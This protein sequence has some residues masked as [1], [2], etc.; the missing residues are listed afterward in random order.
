MDNSAYEIDRMAAQASL[1]EEMTSLGVEAHR[2][3]TENATLNGRESGT[4]AGNFMLQHCIE[5]MTEAIVAFIAKAS[6]GRAGRRHACLQYMQ[7]VDPQVLALI[8]ARV[9]LDNITLGAL[10]SA[11]AVKVGSSVEDEA[12]FSKFEGE[13]KK[14]FRATLSGLKKRTSN[15]GWKRKVLLH[16]MN[17]KTDV[18]WSSWPKAGRL[19]LGNAL[20]E[21]FI[22]NTGLATSVT[23]TVARKRQRTYIEATPATMD[24]IKTRNTACEVLSPSWLPTIV[25]P[26]PWTTPTD[27]G[28]WFTQ[29]LTLV[30][31]GNQN[32]LEELRGCTEQM[33]EVYSAV[34][35]MQATGWKVNKQVLE[36]VN[37]C[38]D[39]SLGIAK[40]P[41][42]EPVD[43]PTRPHDIDTNKESLTMWKRAAARVH[44]A[45]SKASSQRLQV[46]KIL[47]I[48]KRFESEP[49]IFFPTQLDF[50]GRSYCIPQQLN[51]Q[52]PDVAKSLLTFSEGK[53]LGTHNAVEWLAVHGANCF[54]EDKSSLAERIA[55]VHAHSDE[56]EQVGYAPMDNL[57]WAGADKPFQFLAFCYEWA[58]YKRHGLSFVSH[59]PIA[60]DGTCNGLQ[61]FSALLR[62]RVGGAA[63]NLV[64]SPTPNDIYQTVA[65]VVIS[66][67]DSICTISALTAGGTKEGGMAK[68][69]NGLTIDRKL[70]KRPVMVLPY[71]GTIFSTRAYVYEWMN[72][73]PTL[74]WVESSEMF[75]ASRF[76]ADLV[77]EAIGEVVVSA[78]EAMKWLQS[79]AR[80]TTKAGIPVS[81]TTPDGLPILQSYWETDTQLVKTRMGD[82][83]RNIS[84]RRELPS[85]DSKR[86]QNG[87]SPNFIHALDA[88]AMRQYVLLAET[89]GISSF[90]LIH[91][92]YG[93]HAA[94][95]EVSAACIRAAFVDMYTETN[96]LEDFRDQIASAL[97]LGDEVIAETPERGDLVLEE[98]LDSEYFFA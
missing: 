56:I 97:A 85:L 24:L 78:K 94:D 13:S 45:N 18:E 74:P 77:W 62:D 28:Y 23:R 1:E 88:T 29:R 51:P 43:L 6:T 89:N 5:P 83:V 63:T 72:E 93:T 59:L 47:W 49:E 41:Q 69:W 95:A 82:R 76:M 20:L 2:L 42:Q 8:T 50:R 71:G 22:Q 31:T 65:D 68:Q 32:Y 81:W 70:T 60:M 27:G 84:L 19:H 36:V 39:R 79:V 66:K 40:L 67:L 30:K 34:N 80:S 55:W 15:V 14:L 12:R 54:G 57:W 7:Q 17:Q 38:W 44:Q 64:P 91:D 3:R 90:A 35:T 16:T 86:Q 53:A 73:Q 96:V 61:H 92:S 10:Y 11:C 4:D 46:A 48:A 87:I 75:A 98:V 37:E 9:V 21:L 25:P 58:G 33:A 52:G 26:K